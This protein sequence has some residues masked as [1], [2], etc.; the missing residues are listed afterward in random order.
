[1]KMPKINIRRI[2]YV[3]VWLLMA[4]GT[5]TLLVSAYAKNQTKKCT[6]LYIQI[7]G[8]NNHFFVDKQDVIKVIK[9]YAGNKV[10]GKLINTFKLQ[11]IEKELEKNP[12]ISKAVLYFDIKGKL[13]AELQEREP[14]ARLFTADGQTFY[15]DQEAKVLPLSSEHL[16]EVPIF[17]GFSGNPQKLNKRDSG[18]MQ[19]V[20]Y[21]SLYIQ[22]DSFLNN[23]ID[24]VTINLKNQF[25]L[26]PSLG[27][28]EILFGDTSDLA[29]KFEKF[30]LFYK[31]AIPI[32]GWNRYNKLDLTYKNM[33]VAKIKDA[34]DVKADS[35]RAIQIMK[36]M[37]EYASMKAEDTI[38]RF[39]MDSATN[40][41]EI[42]MII[43][44]LPR[45]YE[46][47]AVIDSTAGLLMQNNLKSNTS[48]PT[49][50][51]PVKPPS[52]KNPEEKIIKTN[53]LNKQII[54]PPKKKNP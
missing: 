28:Q 13:N 52:N 18:L 9:K 34:A 23:M 3:S 24:Q 49:L 42:S 14:V 54:S 31:K 27:K 2:L 33:V 20:R 47:E 6:G 44:S 10:D 50:P 26:V 46:T 16:A 41:R 29:K 19:S 40:A 1:M 15:I 39:V 22:Q 8:P 35:L 30:S 5:I 7:D 25:E 32:C 48:P 4:A 53:Q 17:T 36:K 43:Q 45:E 11:N 51:P 21:M 12:W 38:N 37:A